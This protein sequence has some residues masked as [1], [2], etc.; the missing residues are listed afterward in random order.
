MRLYIM[1]GKLSI[2]FDLNEVG[3]RE[4]IQE[5]MNISSYQSFV[6]TLRESL[7]QKVRDKSCVN[8]KH[9]QAIYEDLYNEINDLINDLKINCE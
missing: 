7:H 8:N 5:M 1:K 6:Y 9:Q 2:N 4:T 3:E